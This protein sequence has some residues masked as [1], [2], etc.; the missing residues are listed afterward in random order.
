MRFRARG[1]NW[2]GADNQEKGTRA[3]D[4]VEY[5]GWKN[6]LRLGN[7]EVEI[8]LTTDVGP[9]AIRAGF[10]GEENLFYE[11]PEQAGL[12]GGGEF[13]LYGGH[14]LWHAP[15]VK[16]RTYAPENRPV[17]AEQRGGALLLRPPAEETTGIRKEWDVSMVDGQ[18]RFVLVHRLVNE[19]PWAVELAPWCLSV[20]GQR[21]RAIVPQEEYRP[22]TEYLLPARPLVLWH[23]TDMSDPRF[24]WGRRYLQLRQ[25]PEREQPQKV[26][27]LNA[28][29]WAAYERDGTVFLKTYPVWPDETYPDFGCNTELFTNGRFLELET[30]GPLARL[31]PG[32]AVEYTETWTLLKVEVGPGDEEIEASLL[33]ALEP[34]LP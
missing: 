14:R 34:W 17:E 20:M 13:R 32:E 5:G 3:M 21:G 18:N 1:E 23:Y 11:V 26:G 25:D 22:H 31:E 28:R 27:L 30:L 9:R 19:G 24:T 8:L 4:T 6:C 12:T 2:N 33:P 29:G 10:V 7:D 16:P 15:E